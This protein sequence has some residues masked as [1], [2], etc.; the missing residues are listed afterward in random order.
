M[1][2]KKLLDEKLIKFV[3]SQNTDGLH[4]RSGVDFH[5]IAELHGNGFKELCKECGR[6]YFR[7][8]R[9]R[10]A[11]RKVHGQ[12]SSMLHCFLIILERTMEFILTLNH[13]SGKAL[14]KQNY[15]QAMFE[16]LYFNKAK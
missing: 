11:A 4:I 15:R 9:T 13:S 12:F 6:V 16:S 1:S 14:S 7:D 3:V 10:A 5:K 8:F 2:I